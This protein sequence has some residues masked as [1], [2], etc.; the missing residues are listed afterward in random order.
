MIAMI[1]V[2]SIISVASRTKTQASALT[3]YVIEINPSICLTTDDE[4]KIVTAYSLNSDGDILLSNENFNNINGQDFDICLKH[5]IDLSIQ[6]GFITHEKLKTIKLSVINNKESFANEK[7]E[8]AK[9]I[10]E[11]R[12]K[13]QG[14]KNFNIENKFM[15]VPEFRTK[16]G[17]SRESK[18]LD[19]Y[20]EDIMNHSRF[21]NPDFIIPPPPPKN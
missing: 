2:F 16:M 10:F 15:P 4:N 19:E 1:S 21:F 3:S 13:K 17:F 11:E 20:K 18:N 9:A 14:Y 5:I 8:Y 6:N 7:G 12:L